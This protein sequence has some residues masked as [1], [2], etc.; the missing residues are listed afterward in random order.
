MSP[1]VCK[2]TMCPKFSPRFNLPPRGL[3]STLN[4]PGGART[5]DHLASGSTPAQCSPC[6]RALPSPVFSPTHSLQQ[7]FLGGI[8][9]KGTPSTRYGKA[10]QTRPAGPAAHRRSF[11]LLSPPASQH[12]HAAVPCKEGAHPFS[13]RMRV[14]DDIWDVGCRGEERTRKE[15]LAI[16]AFGSSVCAL[17]VKP[18]LA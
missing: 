8:R 6:L 12:C 7:D 10:R 4:R 16:Q 3:F 11:S 14:V 9:L 2:E 18:F 5:R 1:Q 15:G 17:L 13:H